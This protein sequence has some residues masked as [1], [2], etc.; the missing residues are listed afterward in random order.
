MNIPD[1]N[2]FCPKC[3]D[4]KLGLCL[5]GKDNFKSY[6]CI[7]CEEEFYDRGDGLLLTRQEWHEHC[8]EF[9]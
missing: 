9:Q 7:E 2:P 4:K 8:E 3:K 1:N 6:I 5:E